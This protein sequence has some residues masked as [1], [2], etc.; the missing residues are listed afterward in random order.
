MKVVTTS[1]KDVLIVEQDVFGDRRGYFMET[2]HKNRYVSHCIETEFVQD[3][4]SHST[5]RTLRGLHYQFPNAQ[6]KLIQVVQG[7][8]FDVAVDIRRDSPSFGDWIGVYL[9]DRNKRQLYIPEGFAHGFCVISDTALFS[10]KCNAFYDPDSEGGI[11]WSDPAIGIDWPLDNFLL[12]DKDLKYPCLKDVPVERL[13][14]VEADS[15]RSLQQAPMGRSAGSLPAK[16]LNS[17][18][19]LSL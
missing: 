12:S 15:C 8:V 18:L 16:D 1:L 17:A 4:L 19:T 7:E 11:L 10:Y 3:N 14:L 5:G 6:A 2:Y 9:S 13:P